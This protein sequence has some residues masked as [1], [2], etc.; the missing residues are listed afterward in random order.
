MP[1][2]GCRRILNVVLIAN[3]LINSRIKFSNHRAVCKLNKEKAYDHF[4]WEFLFYMM[5]RMGF[6]EKWISWIPHCTC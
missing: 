2:L 3:E 1:L 5:R 6:G 4:N